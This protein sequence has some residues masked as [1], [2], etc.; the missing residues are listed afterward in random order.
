M[1]WLIQP[2]GIGLFLAAALLIVGAR[3][4]GQSFHREVLLF[5]AYNS[6]AGSDLFLL[7]MQ[8]RLLVN[9]TNNRAAYESG[10]DW[11]GDGSYIVY[12]ASHNARVG[13]YGMTAS[14]R[15]LAPIETP[16]T[17]YRTPRWSPDGNFLA[18][19]AP[20]A[21]NNDLYVLPTNGG[22]LYRPFD[23]ARASVFL[24]RWSPNSD[25]ILYYSAVGFVS[26][27]FVGDVATG[28][29][30]RIARLRPADEIETGA[31]WSPDGA[32]IAYNAYCDEVPGVVIYTLASQTTRC[33]QPTAGTWL[34]SRPV[35]SPDGKS[36][37][38]AISLATSQL[39]L[40]RLD[41]T[42]GQSTSYPLTSGAG[43]IFDIA[44]SSNGT[45]LIF[46]SDLGTG[47]LRLYEFNLLTQSIE[48]LS[49]RL[50]FAF[51]LRP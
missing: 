9:L 42:S 16:L 51:A 37:A 44:W 5:E 13:L 36:I 8:T 18:F 49:D 12:T 46:N 21:S 15:A 17:T 50:V 28:E 23:T 3:G 19:L 24:P 29:V 39:S 10:F 6:A 48:Q 34:R 47:R 26:G 30:T 11:S 32:H 41:I 4:I 45:R 1:L 31:D 40:W 43:I 35:W 33:W 20:G 14:G 22:A 38:I 7:D 25:K 2:L 27:L